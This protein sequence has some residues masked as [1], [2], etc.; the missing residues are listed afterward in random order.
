MALKGEVLRK[1]ERRNQNR[2]AYSR[3]GA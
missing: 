1:R 2:R 3:R